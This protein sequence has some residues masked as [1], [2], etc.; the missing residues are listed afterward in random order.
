MFNSYLK[1]KIFPE[2]ISQI[3]EHKENGDQ[4][5]LLTGSLDFIVMPIAEYL[6]VDSVLAPS[7]GELGSR[8]VGELK[9]EPLIG[10][11]KAIVMK[12]FAEDV[13]ISL[14]VCYA[15]GD[16]QSDLPMLNCVGN[17]VVVNPSRALRQKALST[18]WE[19][20]EWMQAS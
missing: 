15:Y 1:Q 5:V 14:D 13:G 3:E 8:F 10:E 19:M 20:H 9:S 16:S 18:G 17:P 2:A 7:L 11:Q 12:K 6:G 4:I